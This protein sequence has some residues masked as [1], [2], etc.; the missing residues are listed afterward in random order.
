MCV[1]L[2]R[3]HL[4]A[5]L[6]LTNE[7][8]KE[9][10]K[11]HQLRRLATIV[12]ARKVIS[13]R[14]FIILRSGGGLTS[15]NKNNRSQ[16]FIGAVRD[17]Y[18]LGIREKTLRL[19]SSTNLKVSNVCSPKP[20]HSALRRNTDPGLLAY[21]QRPEPHASIHRPRDKEK[22]RALGTRIALC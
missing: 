3:G 21:P 13:V 9:R 18:F 10:L 19:I 1:F 14:N 17:E 2:P 15:F 22:R 16:K 8:K 6:Y 11:N 12:M 7:K 4:R 5:R 20:S